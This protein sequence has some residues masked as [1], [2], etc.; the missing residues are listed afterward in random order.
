[1][2][3]KKEPLRMKKQNFSLLSVMSLLCLAACSEHDQHAHERNLS[4]QE[5]YDLHCADCHQKTGNGKFL[6]GVPPSKYTQL[7]TRQ[8]MNKMTQGSM[9]ES[10]MKVF[11]TMSD[12]EA[13]TIA[14]YV[15]QQLKASG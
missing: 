12:T 8:L 4:G 15:K 5:L 13:E 1:M 7:T 9:T 14:N 6:K 2:K 3:V 10:K 11:A